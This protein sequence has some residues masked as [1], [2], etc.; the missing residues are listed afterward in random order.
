MNV[1]TISMDKHEARKAFELY[2]AAVKA[3]HSY[4]DKA[5]MDGYRALS[6]GLPV[7][8]VREA[9]IAAGTDHLFHPRLAIARADFKRCFYRRWTNGSARFAKERWPQATT[10]RGGVFN[11]S[12]GSLPLFKGD[13]VE[14]EAV[15]P[16]IPPQFRPR[17][18]LKRYH[19]LWEA[20]WKQVPRDPMLLRH[21]GGDLFAVLAVW[22]L[23]EIER[24]VLSGT[25]RG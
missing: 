9:I 12:D 20:D 25:R 5:I 6:K 17:G 22:D 4:E 24:A 19:I 16:N 23:T 3:R 2:H 15:V 8:N 14:A 1:T 18:S 11:F 10:I 13:T 21:L 7:I